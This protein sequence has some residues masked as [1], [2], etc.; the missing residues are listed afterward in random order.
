VQRASQDEEE[1]EGALSSSKQQLTQGKKN[2]VS[3]A[4]A[5]FSFNMTAVL[6]RLRVPRAL[7]IVHESHGEAG[8]WVLENLVLHGRADMSQVA[9][10]V[11]SRLALQHKL[12][13]EEKGSTE[14]SIEYG[15]FE[16]QALEVA[17]RMAGDRILAP[18][19]AARKEGRGAFSTQ[20]SAILDSLVGNDAPSK[21]G[22]GKKASVG[23]SSSVTA[24]ALPDRK[25]RK[26]V[27]EP[28]AASPGDA[29]ALPLEMRL[30]LGTG[31][32]S[33]SSGSNAVPVGEEI[34][35]R[36]G[37]RGRAVA[38]MAAATAAAG[39]GTTASSGTGA[40]MAPVSFTPGRPEG[41]AGKGSKTLWCINWDH[42]ARIQRNR[43]IIDLV[44]QRMGAL[45]GTVVKIILR[46]SLPQELTPCRQTLHSMAM[47][48]AEIAAAIVQELGPSSFPLNS[49][50]KL[51][52]L[53][54]C[55]KV[56]VLTRSAASDVTAGS[57]GLTYAVNVQDLIKYF[58]HRTINSIICE[59]FG[60]V[61]GRVFE[62]LLQTRF[63]DQQ[64]IGD[65]VIAPSREVRK[66][67]YEMYKY[68]LI[69]YVDI[70]KRGD[71]NTMSTLFLWYV[72][73]AKAHASLM[74]YL[75]QALLNVRVRRDF[76]CEQRRDVMEIVHRDHGVNLDP[77]VSE[78]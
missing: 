78:R 23:V 35:A 70:S 49:L 31:S 11:A 26:V 45:A 18:A 47:T 52:E 28:A 64:R 67:M 72:N 17:Q 3:L 37:A 8:M 34:A 59:R 1:E 10:D 48:T 51:L 61:S 27:H 40:P 21:K 69:D 76:E 9:R 5:S 56:S 74:D 6:N 29:N 54:R 7:E 36:V 20:G 46:N 22:A 50:P 24:V 77:I 42:L 2:A 15:A 53:M 55:D 65:L 60:E 57:S 33:S 16:L 62:L 63:L 39:G 41:V 58:K 43:F 71:F 30:L 44:S 66:Q 12:A 14:A 38:R 73:P 25:R 13:Q 32:N 75:Y 68:H 19:A 4:S